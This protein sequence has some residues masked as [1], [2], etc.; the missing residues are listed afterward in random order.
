[1]NEAKPAP[2]KPEVHI[3]V[4]ADDDASRISAVLEALGFEV[5]RQLDEGHG[6]AR[7]EWAVQRLTQR[8]RLTSRESEVLAGVLDGFDNRVLAK[9][10][11]I[12]RATVKWHVHN[13][14]AK[15]GVGSRE[16]LLR[17]ALQLGRLDEHWA[18]PHEVTTK[19][20]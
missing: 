6:S 17:A 11:S 1:M 7:L 20:E 4:V 12:T 8:H 10:L 19:I 3:H 15:V 2:S 13:V 9:H 16:A 14:F 5:V 18:G